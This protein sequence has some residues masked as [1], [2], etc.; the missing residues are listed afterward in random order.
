MTVDIECTYLDT[1][2]CE[3]NKLETLLSNEQWRL[4]FTGDLILFAEEA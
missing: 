1:N 2:Y 4:N 3:V